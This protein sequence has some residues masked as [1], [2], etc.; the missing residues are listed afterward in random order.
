MKIAITGANG[1]IGHN[2]L[3]EYINSHHEIKA[4]VRSK[5]NKKVI[6]N[7]IK[8]IHL[9][10]QKANDQT[11]KYLDEPDI[12]IHLAWSSL[13]DY[14]SKKH[15]DEEL[16]KSFIFLN[17]MI[18]S[19]LKNLL[20][21]GTC[22]EYGIVDGCLSEDHNTSPNNNYSLAKDNLR[23]KI[24][25]LAKKNDFKFTWMR[26]FYVYGNDQNKNTIYTQLKKNVEMKKI[27]FNMSKGNQIRDYLHISE[28]VEQIKK[29]SLNNRNNGIVNLCS[30]VGI[31]MKDLVNKWI[32]VNN[33]NIK[34]NLGYYEYNKDEPMSFWG[35][36]SKYKKI[37]KIK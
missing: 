26:I 12:L 9:D 8:Y 23:K 30:G 32:K 17:K 2:L 5:S 20:V 7:N 29:L 10:Y 6:S 18:N 13:D 11:F 24:F 16:D 25:D 4:I 22:F 1:F 33:W 27:F 34:V 28:L 36:N 31:S 21:A 3:L 37:F 15:I 19:G 14:D 35:N